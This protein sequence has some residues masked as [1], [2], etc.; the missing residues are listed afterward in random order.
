MI[1]AGTWYPGAVLNPAGIPN[2]K[3]G[4]FIL[5]SHNPNAGKNVIFEAQPV[6]VSKNSTD[7]KTAMKI[8]DWWMSP[9]GNAVF[10][11]LAN[12]YSGNPKA[13]SDYLPQ[14]KKILLQTIASEHYNVINRFWEATPTPIAEAGVNI[15]AKFILDTDN[16]D[17]VLTELE[18]FA[19][20]YWSKQK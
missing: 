2:E 10:A 4:Y 9:K 12:T 19:H 6:F 11:K 18:K 3:I 1:L 17:D 5:P 16:L 13:N 7:K 15:L 20:R 14:Q 8:A